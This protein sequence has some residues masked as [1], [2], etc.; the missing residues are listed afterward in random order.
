VLS[1]SI[2]V[3]TVFALVLLTGVL[4]LGDVRVVGGG[5]AGFPPPVAAL[6][7]LLL[8]VYVGAHGLQRYCFLRHMRVAL[9][10]RQGLVAFAGGEA[11]ESL[12]IGIYFAN[13]LLERETGV[14]VAYTAAATLVAILLEV[15][16]CC[17][18]LVLVGIPAWSWLRPLIL[19][20]LALTMALVVA[21]EQLGARIHT[22]VHL[23]ERPAVR[24]FAQQVIEFR[25][26][27]HALASP[28][29]LL[30]GF[31]LT[32]VCLGAAGWPTT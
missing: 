17:L 3:P 7:F 1:P 26:G 4:S 10:L 23:K 2:L 6:V 15:A 8:L 16:F 19:G 22:P 29:V 24:W 13:Y 9:D 20:G 27:A 25:R 28:R 32:A 14:P 21:I 31:G 5:I 30:P 11:T 12:P 18:Y